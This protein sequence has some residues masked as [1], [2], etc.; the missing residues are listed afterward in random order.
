MFELI[1]V[2]ALMAIVPLLLW[3]A[4]NPGFPDSRAARA[5]LM[6][7][8]AL[9]IITLCIH[10]MPLLDGRVFD[11]SVGYMQVSHMRPSVVEAQAGDRVD[12]VFDYYK[13]PGCKGLIQIWMEDDAGKRRR[14]DTTSAKWAEGFGTATATYLIP[15]YTMPGNYRLFHTAD[16][17]C[18]AAE[19]FRSTSPGH[20]IRFTSPKA[21]LTV[22]P[23]QA[24]RKP[25]P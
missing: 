23:T 6:G 18:A 10:I 8:V 21:R 3:I 24:P 4:L 19:G 7:S 12:I 2:L 5:G 14:L 16:M 15:I 20:R 1:R 9:H 11:D 17:K 25:S 13:R 22:L